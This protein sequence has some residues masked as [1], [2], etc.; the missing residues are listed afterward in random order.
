MHEVT[1]IK[2]K[3]KIMKLIISYLKGIFEDHNDQKYSLKYELHGEKINRENLRRD[4][5]K[6]N[7]KG[8]LLYKPS[9]MIDYDLTL[10]KIKEAYER[11]TKLKLYVRDQEEKLEKTQ[12]NTEEKSAYVP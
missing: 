4:I 12:R 5:L 9:L 6:I 10:N 2:G 7:T 8:G 1:H 11:I 3:Q